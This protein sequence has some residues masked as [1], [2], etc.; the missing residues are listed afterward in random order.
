MYN[1]IP[2]IEILGDRVGFPSA[3]SEGFSILNM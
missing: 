3:H 1:Q 2:L